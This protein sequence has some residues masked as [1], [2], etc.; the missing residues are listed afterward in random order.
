MMHYYS[1]GFF[2]GGF[3]F[4]ILIVIIIAIVWIIFRNENNNRNYYENRYRNIPN[5]NIDDNSLKILNERYAK[6]E[7]SEDEYLRMKENIKK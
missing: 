4:F 6:G 7:I 5:D 1:N 2:G 3:M